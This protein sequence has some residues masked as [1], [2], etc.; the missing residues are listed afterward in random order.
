MLFQSCSKTEPA[1]PVI[2]VTSSS[3]GWD[4]TANTFT[5]EVGSSVVFDISVTAEGIF[6][7]MRITDDAGSTL[8]EDSRTEDGQT[9]YTGT[10]TYKLTAENVGTDVVLTFAGIDD[11]AASSQVTATIVTN[12][13]PVAAVKYSA[14]LMYSPM[15]DKTSKTFLSTDDGVTY[16]RKDVEDTPEKVS[17]KIDFGYYYGATNKASIVSPATY[18]KAVYDISSWGTKNATI[19]KLAAMPASH[20]EDIK[21]N[22]DIASHWTM[23]DMGDADGDVIN[24]AVGDIVA[25]YLDAAKGAKKGYFVVRT[26]SGTAGSNDYIEIDVV[27][28]GE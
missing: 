1:E 28:E 26:I 20:F 9:S 25:F 6:N 18:P 13:K 3:D 17:Q 11:E 8:K 14:R 15:A 19:M 7:T 5:G 24:L 12:A 10:Y 27:V 23:T 2:V 16:S 21:N 22:S 4:G